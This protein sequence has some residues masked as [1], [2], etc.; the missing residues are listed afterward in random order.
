M[1]PERL[2]GEEEMGY[3]HSWGGYRQ[4]GAFVTWGVMLAI[5]SNTPKGQGKGVM[6]AIPQFN[7][8]PP[9]CAT[10]GRARRRVGKAGRPE[11]KSVL[12]A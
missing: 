1:P 6:L 2:N 12:H 11:G 8:P 5:P 7:V 3:R 4:G 10:R 9:T